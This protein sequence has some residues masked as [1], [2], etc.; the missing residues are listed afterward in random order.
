MLART[1]K[2]CSMPLLKRSVL[3]ATQLVSRSFA[4]KFYDS[5]LFRSFQ[6][7]FEYSLDNEVP[8]ADKNLSNIAKQFRNLGWELDAQD[9]SCEITLM[10]PIAEDEHVMVTLR[11]D[12]QEDMNY[13]EETGE[14]ANAPLEFRI[15]QN[16]GDQVTEDAGEMK[17]EEEEDESGY[18]L[19]DLQLIFHCRNTPE[20]PLEVLHFDCTIPMELEFEEGT[21]YHGPPVKS[22]D[23]TVQKE[24][25]H[26]VRD[27]GINDKFLSLLRDFAI[28]KE[29]MEYV[30]WLKKIV[31]DPETEEVDH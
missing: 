11:A 17:N 21:I 29:Y 9:G 22:L 5:P 20:K 16:V 19:P 1:V 8:D 10:K 30:N 18:P 7:E 28:D 25:L 4:T 6:K 26:H 15:L 12:T 27:L 2:L 13:D 24:L 23:E 3:P 31:V 14:L